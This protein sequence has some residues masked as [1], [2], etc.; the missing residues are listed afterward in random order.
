MG[1]YCIYSVVS[2]YFCSIL[3]LRDSTYAKIHSFSLLCKMWLNI[4][5]PVFFFLQMNILL[6]PQFLVIMDNASNDNLV[7]VFCAEQSTC[8]S[9]VYIPKSWIV[10]Y[11]SFNSYFQFSKITFWFNSLSALRVPDD[12]VSPSL[13][14]VALQILTTLCLFWCSFNFYFPH[15][16]EVEQIVMF[17]GYFDIF[18]CEASVCISYISIWL[19][20]FSWL[21]RVV[22]ICI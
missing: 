18:L 16:S 14:M 12:P 21:V 7:C 10:E 1:S 20:A 22:S 2:I 5:N 17:S 11:G 8:I 13:G 9:V 19:F 6:P 15:N 4:Y 3:C